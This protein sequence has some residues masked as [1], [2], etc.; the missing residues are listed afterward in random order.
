[1]DL[2][3]FLMM[4][5]SISWVRSIAS[6][7]VRPILPGRARPDAEPGP[8]RT[9]FQFRR[10]APL[11]QSA[12]P[13]TRRPGDKR[14]P[15]RATGRGP[16]D[17]PPLRGQNAAPLP[18]RTGRPASA[19]LRAKR[20]RPH[21]RT[22]ATRRLAAPRSRTP[23]SPSHDTGHPTP[24]RSGSKTPLHS[25]PGA[26]S[27]PARLEA[28]IL[29]G[30]STP[31]AC[32]LTLP[33]SFPVFRRPRPTSA[34]GRANRRPRRAPPFSARASPA[35]LISSAPC[36]AVFFFSSCRPR[37]RT[38]PA[39]VLSAPP[40]PFRAPRACAVTCVPAVSFSLAPAFGAMFFRLPHFFSPAAPPFFSPRASLA[41]A[42][43]ASA[44]YYPLLHPSAAPFRACL[45]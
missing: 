6:L 44:V 37:R 3:Y 36:A 28:V 40:Y 45:L 23:P 14:P 1:M 35:P 10:F 25:R 20:R 4:L 27:A 38:P 12:P 43:A 9:L 19:A 33:C 16:T 26:L 11:C 31:I 41:P 2:R 24:L 8:V 13:G 17:A 21:R 29:P 22:R 5:R 32:S 39:S 30:A 15:S 7:A 42:H 34:L 18:R